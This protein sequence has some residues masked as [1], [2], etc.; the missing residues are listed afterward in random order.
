MGLLLLCGAHRLC[1]VYRWVVY[2]PHQETFRRRPHWRSLPLPSKGYGPAGMN[3]RPPI[4]SEHF[5]SFLQ[6][7]ADIRSVTIDNPFFVAGGKQC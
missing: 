1:Q 2:D 4:E 5:H 7:C 3:A 6:L